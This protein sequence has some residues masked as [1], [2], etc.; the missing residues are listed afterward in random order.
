MKRVAI[1]GAGLQC[2]RRASV[3]VKDK[4]IKLVAIAS[5][6]IDHAKNAAAQYG[7][8]ASDKWEKTIERDDIDIVIICTPPYIHAEIAIKSMKSGKH[9]LCEKPLTRTIQE[10]EEMVIVAKETGKI[11]KCGFN[12]RHH[13]A[14]W[15][16][17]KVCNQGGIGK[18]LFARCRYGICGRPGYEKEWRANPEMAAG[19]QF[20]E[21]GTHTIDF[22]LVFRRHNRNS[23]YD[24]NT[25]F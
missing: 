2:Q 4:G 20:I 14:I 10:A 12:H 8:E 11:L 15:E 22:S 19:G 13:P 21:Q 24:R 23:L 3:L 9:V 16:A 17:K 1:I 18:P 6:H 7:C 5:L 25:V